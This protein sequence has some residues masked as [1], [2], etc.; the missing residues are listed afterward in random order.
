MIKT[1]V[2]KGITDRE[3]LNKRFLSVILMSSL[4]SITLFAHMS[5]TALAQRSDQPISPSHPDVP[6]AKLIY[7]N[8]V[9]DMSPFVFINGGQLNK[10]SFP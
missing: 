1:S 5:S 3:I 6:K 7:N 2:I 10:I 4:V 9:Y 8:N